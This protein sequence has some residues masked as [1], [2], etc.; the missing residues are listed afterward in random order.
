MAYRGAIDGVLRRCDELRAQVEELSGETREA[1]ACADLAAAFAWEAELE[2]ALRD[3]EDEAADE[4]AFAS[5]RHEPE[6]ERPRLSTKQALLLVGGAAVALA[7]LLGVAVVVDHREPP[8]AAPVKHWYL[9]AGNVRSGAHVG[10]RCTI[11]VQ[12]DD[13][14]CNVDVTCPSVERRYHASRCR[15]DGYVEAKVP[16]L[17]LDGRNGSLT[18][19]GGEGAVEVGLD[20]WR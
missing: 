12:M 13:E 9:V 11:Y 3:L 19:V 10:D 5:V 14:A 1:R 8:A 6:P 15:A 2:R 4:R 16:G 18:F 17:D 20:E 7:A